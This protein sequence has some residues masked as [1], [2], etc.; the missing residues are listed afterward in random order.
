MLDHDIKEL[1]ERMTDKDDHVIIAIR[2]SYV[3]Q[4]AEDNCGRKLTEAELE[5]LSWLAL[6]EDWYLGV[7]LDEVIRQIIKEAKLKKKK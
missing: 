7:W 4:F 3:Q 2:G 1:N 6:E 5:E